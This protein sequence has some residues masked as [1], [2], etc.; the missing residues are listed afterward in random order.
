MK[1]KIP[2][3]FKELVRVASTRDDLMKIQK[4]REK[5]PEALPIYIILAAKKGKCCYCDNT[6]KI[7]GMVGLQA[8]M[9]EKPRKFI[10]GAAC[11]GCINSFFPKHTKLA[12][13]KTLEK[14]N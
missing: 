10:T 12:V 5:K 2:E 6:S 14:K 1:I 4:F 3:E 13:L 8:H 11:I 9:N 7:R